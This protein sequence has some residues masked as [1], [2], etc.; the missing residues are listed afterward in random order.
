MPAHACSPGV[1]AALWGRA[2]GAVTPA[3]W[4]RAV[5]SR[6]GGAEPWL[7]PLPSHRSPA[8]PGWGV[9]VVDAHGDPTRGDVPKP[10]DSG[11]DGDAQLAALPWRC[12]GAN[13]PE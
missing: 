2:T 8:C 7:S 5:S 9:A 1:A 6:P 13:E 10:R 3:G 4:H 11:A 12:A